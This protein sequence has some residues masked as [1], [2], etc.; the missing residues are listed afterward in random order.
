MKKLIYLAGCLLLLGASSCESFLE[1]TPQSNLTPE[2]S[3]KTEGDWNSTLTAAYGALQNITAG[4]EAKYAIT[5]GEF[6]TDEVK[7]IDLGWA[8]YAELHYYTFSPSHV[9]LD[10]HY[11]LCY[12]GIKR[13][14]IVIDMPAEAPVSDQ[15]RNLMI[16]QAKF[17]R[18]LLY[19][20]LVRM[21]GG[22]PLWTSASVDK[23]QIMKPRSSA[24]AVYQTIVQDLQEAASIL[25][26]SWEA[27]TDKGR[28]TSLAAYALLGRV[29]LQRGNPAEALTAL[30]QVYGKF[31]LYDNYADIFSPDHKNEEYENIFEVQFKHS[32]KWGEEGSLQHSYWG[33][34]NIPGST[35][36]FGGWGGFGPSQYLYDSYDKDFDGAT[37][38]NDRRKE[39]FF[40]TEYAGIPQTPPAIKKFWDS[41]YGNEIENDDLN[42]IY[43]RYA[44]VLLM[45]AEA[46]NAVDDQTD[47]KYDCINEVRTRAGLRPITKQDNLSK[48]AF[49]DAVL[50]ERLKELCCEHLRR[51][52]LIRFGKLIDQVKAAYPDD[53]I[54]IKDYH[55][56]YPIPQSAMDANDA[57]TENNPGY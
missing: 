45:R 44:D 40:W 8:A 16:A 47:A 24:E 50:L 27:S 4:F 30:N 54:G 56:L 23:E 52:D 25:P 9:F 48:Q 34:R 7:P 28:A 12:D 51:F 57:I 20:D 38:T 18:A 17:V 42:F 53:N 41:K 19:F 1:E 22:V 29:Q 14:N 26:A 33:P 5:L 39:D 3:F 49:A 32:G 15:A 37:V 21:Y 43:I 13:C 10:N 55:V 36:A 31:H 2:N 46:L 11:T 6:G 35:T